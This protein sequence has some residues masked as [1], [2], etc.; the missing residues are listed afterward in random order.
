MKRLAARTEKR[1]HPSP[2]DNGVQGRTVGN[3]GLAEAQVTRAALVLDSLP[4]SR[5][6]TNIYDTQFANKI[7]YADFIHNIK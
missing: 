6:H 2:Y 1:K 4:V 3:Q 5:T 7:S